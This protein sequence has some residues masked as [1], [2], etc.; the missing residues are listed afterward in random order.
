MPVDLHIHTTAS[1]GGLSPKQVVELASRLGLSTIAISDHDTV[2][3]IDEALAYGKKLHVKVIPALELSSKF[4]SRDIHV[5]GYFIDHK[6]KKLLK[7]L[8][9]L[10]D[11]R[12]ERAVKIIN[13]LKKNGIAISLDD[14]LAVA[15]SASIGR[16][17][18]ARV[19]HKKNYVESFADAF[20]KYLGKDA[21]CYFEKFVYSLKEAIGIIHEAG[22]LAVFA[23]PG[24]A[25]VDEHISDFIAMGLDGI[26]VYHVDH[27]PEVVAHYKKLAKEYNLLIVGGSDCHGEA[28]RHGLRLGTIPVPDEV[29]DG[30]KAAQS[31]HQAHSPH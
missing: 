28:S 4:N 26:E 15:G 31:T 21:P 20:N 19:L 22:G 1:D 11:S 24:L 27:P 29:A 14:V 8:K 18:I 3:G 25:K 2:K 6:S 17:H 7:A 13:C 30:L 23:H 12:F 16:P 10:R 9:H 5:L